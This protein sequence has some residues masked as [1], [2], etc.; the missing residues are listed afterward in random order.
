MSM[1]LIHYYLFLANPILFVLLIIYC[2]RRCYYYYYYY[3]FVLYLRNI[4][5]G[6]ITQQDTYLE[7]IIFVWNMIKENNW[8]KYK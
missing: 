8:T 4:P 3:L 5:I 7:H 6:Y 2:E 1:R